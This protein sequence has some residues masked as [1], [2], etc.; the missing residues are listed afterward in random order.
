MNKEIIIAG[1]LIARKDKILLLHRMETDWFEVPGGK[2]DDGETNEEAAVREIKEELGLDVKITKLI[3]EN[4][5]TNKGNNYKYIL[6]SAE[7]VGKKV[8]V[9]GEPDTHDGYIWA[10]ELEL[11]VINLSENTRSFLE[12]YPEYF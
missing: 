12:K 10:G 7:I 11:G 2:V 6:F 5:F 4:T 9:I 8:V 1:C 3:G